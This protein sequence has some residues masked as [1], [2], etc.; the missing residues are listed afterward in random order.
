M[1]LKCLEATKVSC[2]GC[3]RSY[4][5]QATVHMN[6]EIEGFPRKMYREWDVL[7]FF[8]LLFLNSIRDI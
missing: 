4:Q 5:P 8:L 1:R 2:T 6:T 7:A 3:P